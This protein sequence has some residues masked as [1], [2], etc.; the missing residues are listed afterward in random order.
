MLLSE[1]YSCVYQE[2]FAETLKY[3]IAHFTAFTTPHVLKIRFS[4]RWE[5]HKISQKKYKTCLNEKD[6]LI[7]IF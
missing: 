6:V 3:P 2:C 4:Y 5:F 7:Q 1:K